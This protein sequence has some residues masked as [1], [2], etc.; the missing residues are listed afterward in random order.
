VDPDPQNGGTP[1]F[2]Y[3][4]DFNN[5]GGYDSQEPSPTIP[6]YD[7]SR[8]LFINP[9]LHQEDFKTFTLRVTVLDSNGKLE[10][11]FRTIIS[12]NV[13]EGGIQLTIDNVEY[14]AFGIA[15][16]PFSQVTGNDSITPVDFQL[17]MSG[18]TGT[19][20]YTFDGNGDGDPDL[21]LIDHDDDP[22]TDP[23]P[24]WGPIIG[25]TLNLSVD[26]QGLGYFPAKFN[27]RAVQGA[28]VAD[29]VSVE[30]PVSL[31]LRRAVAAEGSLATRT[32]HGVTATWDV[33]AGGGNG[34]YLASRQL[35]TSGGSRGTTLL[36][37]VQ[38]VTETFA[39]PTDAGSYETT[40]DVLAA[41]HFSMNLE[42]SGHLLWNNGINVIAHGGRNPI[43]GILAFNEW[44]TVADPSMNSPWQILKELRVPGFYPLTQA[45]GALNPGDNLFYFCGGVHPPDESDVDNVSGKLISYDPTLEASPFNPYADTNRDMVS[46][47]YD[48]AAA[49]SG[50]KMYIIGGRI[51]SG[52]SVGTVE[53]FN[54][55]SG[56]WEALPPM[57][58][59]RSGCTAHVIG[60]QIYVHGGAFYP[61][62]E[63]D[64]TLLATSE[65][66]NPNTGVWSYTLPLETLSD[67]GAAASMPGP[68]AV[69][70]A[71]TS[72]NTIW[73]FGGDGVNGAELNRLEEFVYFYTVFPEEPEEEEL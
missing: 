2:E 37:D 43:N 59:A 19:Y 71:G 44:V 54:F 58:E 38:R 56:S 47:R 36:R 16:P 29:T 34:Q 70:D 66:Y 14:G 23:E 20:E 10:E 48:A 52:E 17:D 8:K 63:T 24:G 11:R 69:S 55:T 64:R 41:T 45:Q 21:P 68:G 6:Y 73:Y 42:R 40:V 13:S 50:S 12:R 30:T 39:Q 26:F 4:W 61:S 18:S 22:G 51:A 65:V 49:I 27:I 7:S 57:L 3:Y 5:D 53:A 1:P 72:I 31:V 67:N 15:G 28:S 46:E 25:G 9:Y 60:G 35:I 62:N 32:N 33:Q